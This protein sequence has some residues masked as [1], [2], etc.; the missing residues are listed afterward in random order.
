M[1]AWKQHSGFEGGDTLLVRKEGPAR[2][3]FSRQAAGANPNRGDSGKEAPGSTS[4]KRQRVQA[5]GQGDMVLQLQQQV[6]QLQQELQQR[7]VGS[8]AGGQQATQTRPGAGPT[9][10]AAAA[11][12]GDAADGPMPTAAAAAA[13][14]PSGRKRKQPHPQHVAAHLAP[15]VVPGPPVP[16][17]AI[18]EGGN[19]SEEPLEQHGEVLA[20]GALPRWAN[21]RQRAQPRTPAAPRE[22]QPAHSQEMGP[23]PAPEAAAVVPPPPPQQQQLGGREGATAAAAL[24]GPSAALPAVSLPAGPGASEAAGGGMCRSKLG[25][26]S[27]EELFT[28]TMLL[29]QVGGLRLGGRAA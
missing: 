29:L 2:F 23:P 4:V 24:A 9:A 5:T 22:P 1:R 15:P 28:D 14:S 11:T 16:G 18:A 17:A 21:K 20:A 10:A 19:E 13:P 27:E 6:Q 3:V 12:A 25:A 26:A 7:G 8:A